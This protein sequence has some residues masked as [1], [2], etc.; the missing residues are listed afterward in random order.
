[1]AIQSGN[2]ASVAGSLFVSNGN[3]SGQLA[4]A[5]ALSITG[6]VQADT[7]VFNHTYL[8]VD[9]C[10][11]Q[12]YSTR[13]GTVTFSSGVFITKGL[14]GTDSGSPFIIGDGTNTANYTMQ[15]GTHSFN[16][17]LV[18]SSNSVLSA[19]GTVN[20]SITN[21]GTII[22]T[23]GCDMDFSGSVVNFG[24][25]L[26]L[27]GTANFQSTFVNQGTFFQNTASVTGLSFSGT[28]VAVQFTTVSNCV[29]DIQARSDLASGAWTT[30]TSGLVGTGSAMTTTD[31]GGAT[32]T[33]R[34]YRILL[35]Y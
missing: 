9:C 2:S 32:N 14:S 22:L 11:G 23:N 17:G 30:L 31:F 33:Q 18:I 27:N 13:Y 3:G 29:H 25:I 15:G 6:T 28:N 19:C 26:A 8:F 7:A 5:G 20:G 21:Y 24:T 34:F 1:M 4:A 35:H 12:Y 16:G 10:G